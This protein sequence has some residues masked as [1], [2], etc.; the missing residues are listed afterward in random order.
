MRNAPF[1]IT[2]PSGDLVNVDQITYISP[3]GTGCIIHFT[4]MRMYSN[5]QGTFEMGGSGRQH[6]STN[7]ESD[8]LTCK[9]SCADLLALINN[10]VALVH[11]IEKAADVNQT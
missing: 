8:Y 7:S 6:G 4:A 5:F 1:F 11:E 2:L 3:D 10:E 9:L